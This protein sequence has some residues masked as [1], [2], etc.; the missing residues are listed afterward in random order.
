MVT[1]CQYKVEGYD[2]TRL[3]IDIIQGT[4]TLIFT[5]WHVKEPT[6]QTNK[7]TKTSTKTNTRT[8][9]NFLPWSLHGMKIKYILSSSFSLT[10]QKCY[11]ISVPLMRSLK[12]KY[13]LS[14]CHAN[15]K[16]KNCL[17]CVCLFLLMFLFV[18]LFGWL[19]L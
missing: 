1:N 12:I 6:N 15:F 16:V 10:V 17:G 2:Y 14:S 8:P 4:I 19:V 7:Q 9:D 13:I 3:S 18:C 11:S 5:F